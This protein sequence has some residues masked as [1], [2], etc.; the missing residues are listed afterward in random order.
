[1]A[2]GAGQ[3]SPEPPSR[4]TSEEGRAFRALGYQEEA[5]LE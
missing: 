3:S 4:L 1:M 5:G 2:K